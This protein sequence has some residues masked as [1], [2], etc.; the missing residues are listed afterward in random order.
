MART[1]GAGEAALLLGTEA[2]ET[3]VKQARIEDYKVLAFATHGLVAGDLTGL[4]E[5]ALVLT[6]PAKGTEQDDG[7]LTASEA[8]LPETAGELLSLARTLGATDEALLLGTEATETRRQCFTPRPDPV[9]PS[10]FG[11]PTPRNGRDALARLAKLR[12]ALSEE[13]EGGVVIAYFRAS[14]GICR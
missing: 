4:S 11:S 3:R 5:P 14:Q 2:T 1:L 9:S 13:T 7:L 10:S 12:S 6:P 8:S